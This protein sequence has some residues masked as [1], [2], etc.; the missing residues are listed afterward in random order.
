MEFGHSPILQPAFDLAFE[1]W[2]VLAIASS[3]GTT[4]VSLNFFY[5]DYYTNL[6]S[7]GGSLDMFPM[8]EILLMKEMDGDCVDEDHSP[9]IKRIII[10]DS[11]LDAS[12]IE[13]S[14]LDSMSSTTQG[15]LYYQAHFYDF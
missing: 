4:D 5:Y 3:G 7:F 10:V 14:Y 11:E 6:A 9:I 15:C 2:Q 13:T 8:D 1:G 12:A